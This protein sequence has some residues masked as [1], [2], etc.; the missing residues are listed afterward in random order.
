MSNSLQPRNSPGQNTEVGGLSLLW[1]ISQTQGFNPGLPHCRRIP[2]Q[3]SHKESPR[4]LEWVAYPFSRGSSQP[5]KQTRVSCIAG[6]FLTNWAVREALSQINW[7][8]IYDQVHGF[9]SGFWLELNIN[10][11]L[12]NCCISLASADILMYLFY[13]FIWLHWVLAAARGIFSC[14]MWDL[15]P[16]PG[17]KPR[18]PALGACILSHWTLREVLQTFLVV[19]RLF[20]FFWGGGIFFKFIF[21]WRLI[22]LQCVGFCCTTAWISHKY[23]H[24]PFIKTILI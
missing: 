9:I 3:L 12:N 21:N 17:I 11:G 16:Q 5:R 2:Y 13:L 24:I 15:V 20:Q 19:Q 8:L 18:P 7:P 4:I 14:N 6:G 10:D 1:G 23:T 22:A